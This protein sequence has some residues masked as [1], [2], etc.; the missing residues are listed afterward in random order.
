M[1]NVLQ[2]LG[3]IGS[4]DEL[5]SSKTTM[6]CKL[7]Q[8]P[9][10]NWMTLPLEAKKCLLN[11]RKRQQKEDDAKKKSL[12]SS[13][14]DTTKNSDKDKNSS[15]LPN[16]YEKVKNSVKG[17][18]EEVQ[19]DTDHTYCF[20]DEYLEEAIN[21]SNIYESR[22]GTD[23]DYCISEHNAHASISMN[24]FLQ[25]KCMNLL[26]L[27][28]RYNVSILDGGADTCVEGLRE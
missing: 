24:N 16:Q 19:D 14:K 6:V 11:K 3:S 23:Y 4:D 28:E 20:I 13:T 22:H 18:E 27:P 26:F 8:V 12:C 2:I 7:S 1:I 15:N 9:P 10:K 21:T 5:D 25:N 17:G